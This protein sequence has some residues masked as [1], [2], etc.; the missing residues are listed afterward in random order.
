MPA[1]PPFSSN[2]CFREGKANCI[3]VELLGQG[4]YTDV[5]GIPHFDA[6]QSPTSRSVRALAL[7]TDTITHKY[8]LQ[9]C[10]IMRKYASHLRVSGGV[11]SQTAWLP[12]WYA[13][14]A[15]D[16]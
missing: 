13:F 3:A 5:A 9:V 14:N 1:F 10:R 2:P 4:E 8:D 6:Q 12:Q 16:V 7:L 11:V 15:Y